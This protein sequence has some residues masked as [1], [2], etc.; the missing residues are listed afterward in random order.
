MEWARH[1]D[2]TLRG[3]GSACCAVALCCIQRCATG[4]LCVLRV[5][6]P[7]GVQRNTDT[8]PCYCTYVGRGESRKSYVPI[9]AKHFLAGRSVGEYGSATDLCTTCVSAIITIDSDMSLDLHTSHKH[10]QDAYG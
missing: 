4:V 10:D 6:P 2:T 5:A 8:Y 1:T 9:V 7:L 3:A